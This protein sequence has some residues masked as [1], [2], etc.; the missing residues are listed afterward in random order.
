MISGF[1]RQAAE[2]IL[3]DWAC[4]NFTT[5]Q[6]KDM[7]ADLDLDLDFRQPDNGNILQAVDCITGD[8]VDLEC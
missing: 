1:R 2:S 5:P 8:Y 3:Y 6:A 4:G 7:L